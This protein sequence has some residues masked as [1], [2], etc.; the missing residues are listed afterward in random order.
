MERGFPDVK[1]VK[2]VVNSRRNVPLVSLNP[3]EKVSEAIGKMRKFD[4]E[5]IPVLQHNEVVGAISESGL[6][7]RLIDQPELKDAAVKAVMQ[8]AF[9]VVGLET[10]IEKLTIYINKENGAVLTK[11]ESGNHHI[12]TKYDI[13]QALGK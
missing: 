8:T 10:P 13:I 7:S 6:F 1:T 12:V 11:D 4:I 3:D 5:H 9:P 2:D